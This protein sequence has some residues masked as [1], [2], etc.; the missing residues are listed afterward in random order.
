[1]IETANDPAA[2]AD[3]QEV[4]TTLAF[5]LSVQIKTVKLTLGHLVI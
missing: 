1:M 2:N 4:L 5:F 3:V